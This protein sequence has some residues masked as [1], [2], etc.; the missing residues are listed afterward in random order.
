M[1]PNILKE[2]INTEAELSPHKDY[3]KSI[4]K[5]S[6]DIAFLNRD[7]EAHESRVGGSPL[8]PKNFVWPT[9]IKGEYRFLGQINFSEISYPLKV[10]PES[11]LLLL[12]YA[13]DENDEIFWGSDGYVIGYFYPDV[14][15]LSLYEQSP[16]QYK[17]KKMVFS[18]GEE[19]PRHEDLRKDW[20]FDTEILADLPYL[21]DYREDYMLGYPSFCTLGYDP[22]PKGDWMSLLTLRSYEKFDWCW[23]D[24]DKLMIFI[25]NEKLKKADFSNLKA[26]AG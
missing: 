10:L 1:N 18:Y 12:F 23:H 21:Q 15:Y 22:T 5:P 4:T 11:G 13:Y 25:E 8:V 9:H 20:P 14:K 17:A 3:L 6:V 24:G 7:A 2:F 16:A 19:I 26:D